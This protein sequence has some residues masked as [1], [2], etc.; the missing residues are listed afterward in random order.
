MRGKEAGKSIFEVDT[1]A[2][3]GWMIKDTIKA[4]PAANDI[5]LA[6]LPNATARLFI[7]QENQTDRADTIFMTVRQA[8]DML[9][10]ISRALDIPVKGFS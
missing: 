1:S 8:Y 2:G 9:T 3:K 4:E 5:V 10:V 7:R 6:Y